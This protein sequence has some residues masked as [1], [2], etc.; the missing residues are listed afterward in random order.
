MITRENILEELEKVYQNIPERVH[1][2]PQPII[3]Y[4]TEYQYEELRKLFSESILKKGE[5]F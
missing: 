5:K 3:Y 4:W 2:E 1:P